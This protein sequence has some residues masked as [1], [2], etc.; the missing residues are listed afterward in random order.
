[1]RSSGIP[2]AVYRIV[3]PEGN[4]HFV[5]RD[6]A[7]L[8]AFSKAHRLRN[9]YVRNMIV[10]GVVGKR[11][12]QHS[13]W[14]LLSCDRVELNQDTVDW[15]ENE[16]GA[17]VVVSGGVPT[18]LSVDRCLDICSLAGLPSDAMSFADTRSTQQLLSGDL[19]TL[20]G[21]SKV[22]EP[23]WVVRLEGDRHCP[24]CNCLIANLNGGDRVHSP[25]TRPQ[26]AVQRPPWLSTNFF[27]VGRCQGSLGSVPAAVA[28][29]L[30]YNA[31]PL[32]DSA[33]SDQ[34]GVPAAPM[35][36]RQ[37]VLLSCVVVVNKTRIF[38]GVWRV[39]YV[40]ITWP[41]ALH[42]GPRAGLFILRRRGLRPE[43][44]APGQRAAL[45]C[46]HVRDRCT[47]RVTVT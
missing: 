22:N 8:L 6:D 4:L 45:P 43:S 38:S 33:A 20:H 40:L 44:R 32:A 7:S 47:R 9:E 37:A 14:Q 18:L 25:G 11:R 30:T 5:P 39:T 26:P 36:L 31:S 10:P 27:R 34:P 2:A 15:L 12:G 46:E 41:V 35:K 23:A 29:P 28:H 42:H 21:W 17:I 16:S 1:M 13:A 19:L 3:S 24:I